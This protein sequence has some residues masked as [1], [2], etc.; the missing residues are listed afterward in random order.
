MLLLSEDGRALSDE[1]LAKEKVKINKYW[2]EHKSDAPKS[3][4]GEEAPWFTALDYSFVG[5]ERYENRDVVK[6]VESQ[7]FFRGKEVNNLTLTFAV[8]K[9]D[10]AD[11][12]R[13]RPM[14]SPLSPD[15]SQILLQ[16]P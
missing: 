6:V 7:T 2:Q 5:N 3:T 14:S 16:N 12:L 15:C 10:G 1:K 8:G 4:A 13:S 9:F 11:G